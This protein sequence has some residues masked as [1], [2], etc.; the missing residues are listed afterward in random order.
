[1]LRSE[2][3]K[4]GI[5]E[6]FENGTSKIADKT[7]YG[8]S[9]AFDGSLAIHEKEARVVRFIF[10][11]YLAGDSLRKIVDALAEKRL[12]SPSGKVKWSCKV[13]DSLLSNEKYVGQVLLQ[14]TT[15][16]NGR[17]V[18]NKTDP[19][20]LITAHH[21]AIISLRLFDAVQT[22]KSKRANLKIAESGLQRKG[23]KYNS[24]YVLSGLL[25]Y[26]ECGSP[27]RRIT[28]ANGEVVWR[29]ANR[30]EHGKVYC[31]DSV[32]VTEVAVKKFLCRELEMP[33]F[34]EQTVRSRVESIM[35]GHDGNFDINFRQ[36]QVLSMTM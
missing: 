14:K 18:R 15:V 19:R 4:I 34:N 28:R 32:T 16:Q 25:I 6:S 8:Y 24:G 5:R 17:Q 35:I 23:T 12:P 1:M 30:V 9:K 20:Y 33:S 21:P 31:K 7:C 11:R 29:C 22:E 10:E 13:V 27:Y 3:I 2:S 36:E 26:G